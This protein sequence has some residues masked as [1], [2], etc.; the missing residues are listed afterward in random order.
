MAQVFPCEFCEISKNTFFHRTALVAT[1]AFIQKFSNTFKSLYLSGALKLLLKKMPKQP[2][3]VNYQKHVH[4]WNTW[5]FKYF[6]VLPMRSKSSS[7]RNQFK[8]L[9]T[10][11]ISFTALQSQAI[12]INYSTEQWGNYFMPSLK[13]RTKNVEISRWICSGNQVVS[14]LVSKWNIKLNKQLPLISENA[15]FPLISSGPQ[16]TATL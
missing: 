9:V 5:N 15:V 14:T 16:K 1:S 3:L 13:F 12:Q 2:F 11:I 7:L 10:G 8:P 4:K 6:E